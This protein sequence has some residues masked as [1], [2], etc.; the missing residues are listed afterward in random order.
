M[1]KIMIVGI[2]AMMAFFAQTGYKPW[3]TTTVRSEKVQP[4]LEKPSVA[5]TSNNDVDHPTGPKPWV[6]TT[7]RS[8][9]L[10]PNLN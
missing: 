2:A 7:V 5:P 8:E 6:T 3:V 9:K 4:N 1:E 10:E